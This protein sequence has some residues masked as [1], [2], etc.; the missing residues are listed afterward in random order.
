MASA[1]VVGPGYVYANFW[2]SVYVEARATQGPQENRKDIGNDKAENSLLDLI[3]LYEAKDKAS[4]AEL[5]KAM[6]STTGP[7][8]ITRVN[9]S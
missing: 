5:E 9:L 2:D 4:N 7:P 6:V 3:R 8:R 1:P